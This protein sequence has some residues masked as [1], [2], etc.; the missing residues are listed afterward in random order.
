MSNF[1]VESDFDYQ[2]LPAEDSRRIQELFKFAEKLFLLRKDFGV[3]G[4]G[5]KFNYSFGK[6]RFMSWLTLYCSWSKKNLNMVGWESLRL[7]LEYENAMPMGS[8]Y[9]TNRQ[10]VETVF[11]RP[12]EERIHSEILDIADGVK[13]IIFS[14]HNEMTNLK[15]QSALKSAPAG[16]TNITITGNHAKVNQNSVDNSTNIINSNDISKLLVKLRSEALSHNLSKDNID[17]IDAIEANVTS[18]KPSKAVAKTLIDSL[19][20][21]GSIASIGSFILGCL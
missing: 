6:R 5:L 8:G 12:F 15:E 16:V 18:D 20:N 19:P 3:L 17:I 9:G 21:L 1:P 2:A 10:M 11:I 14:E 7:H 13:P 4:Y